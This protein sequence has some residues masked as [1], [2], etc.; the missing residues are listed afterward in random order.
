MTSVLLV[1]DNRTGNN[2]GGRGVSLALRSLLSRTFTLAGEIEGRDFVLDH[3]GYGFVGTF[4]PARFDHL[5]MHAWHQRSRRRLFDAYV[6]FEEAYGAADYVSVDASRTVETMLK[7]R[8]S[9]AEIAAILD[10][11]EAADVIVVNGEGEF[12]FTTPPRRAVLLRLAIMEYAHRLGKPAFFVN[13]ML[14]DCPF[15]GRHAATAEQTSRQLAQCAGVFLRDYES[16]ALARTLVPGIACEFVPDALFEWQPRTAALANQL[17]ANGDLFLPHPEEQEWFGR[18]DF[19]R[20]YICVGGSAA[21][22]LEPARAAD[23]YTLVVRG[24]QQLGL[25]VYLAENDGRDGFL[26]EVA[27]RTGGGFVP[28]WTPIMA[29]GAILARAALFVSGRYHPSILAS[30]GGTPSVFLGT[31]AHKTGSLPAVLEYEPV[32]TFPVF[33]DAAEARDIA[34]A[35]RA[36]T[37]EGKARRERVLAAATRRWSE[38]TTLPQRLAA[39]LGKPAQPPVDHRTGPVATQGARDARA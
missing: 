7:Y 8:S 17:P 31:T 33:P 20:P 24:L 3:S 19:S 11:V 25:P 27:R 21:A 10:K 26:R 1:G 4:L 36:L 16:I 29:A 15:T 5:F 23:S 12:V 22:A 14:S 35:G 2:W 30:L 18:L 34:E 28:V 37:A 38:V 6:K 39:R 9:I 13:A 32:R